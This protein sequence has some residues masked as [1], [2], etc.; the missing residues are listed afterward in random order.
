MVTSDMVVL[1]HKNIRAFVSFTVEMFSKI[2]PD[3]AVVES[4]FQSA[5]G[6]HP[7]AVMHCQRRLRLTHF[8]WSAQ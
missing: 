4:S 1:R 5:C 6:E 7:S 8:S 3:V 2:G